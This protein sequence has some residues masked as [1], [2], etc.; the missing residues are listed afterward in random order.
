MNEKELDRICL[1]YT[2]LLMGVN[3]QKKSLK[4]HDFLFENKLSVPLDE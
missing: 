1:E 3:L 2:N 4:K